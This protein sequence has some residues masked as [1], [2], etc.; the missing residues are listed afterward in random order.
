MIYPDVTVDEWVKRHPICVVEGLCV[1]G[2]KAST[3]IPVIT[4]KKIGLV[5]PRCE[6]GLTE[7]VSTYI[8][9]SPEDR[10]KDM[11]IFF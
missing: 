6:C 9:K 2:K 7:S 1:C 11:E 4:N 10:S 5:S 3:T 8:S